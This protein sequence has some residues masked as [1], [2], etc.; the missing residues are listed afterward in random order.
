ME[1]TLLMV[2]PVN[3]LEEYTLCVLWRNKE[4]GLLIDYDT[5]AEIAEEKSLK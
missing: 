1:V 4:T 5:V 2:S 3:F